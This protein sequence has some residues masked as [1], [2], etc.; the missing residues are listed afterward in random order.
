M[1]TK[2]HQMMKALGGATFAGALALAGLSGC[3]QQGMSCTTAH[4]SFA[5]K[6]TLT[7]GTGA[8]SEN[9]GGVYGVNSYNYPGSDGRPDFD[10]ASMAIEAEDIALAVEEAEGRLSADIDA[11]HTSYAKGDFGSAE[12][13][14]SDVC[15]VP[16]LTVA[17]KDIPVLPAVPD[18]PETAEDDE[19]LP[20]KPA[21]SFKYEWTNMKW[22]VSEA[23]PGTQFVADLKYTKDG[24]TADFHAIGM[25]PAVFC[26]DDEGNP[27]NAACEAEAN[28]D[29]G[30]PTGS[31][32][33]PDF[34]TEC[35]PVLLL[36]M[37]KEA[38]PIP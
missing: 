2:S 3:S 17:Q 37:L 14:G 9:P 28:P 36:C 7:S 6:L 1:S 20:E 19:S 16:T 22:R 13:N 8:C 10:K 11:A 27:D 31:G 29:E 18:D 38:P 26:G 23:V 5:V 24:C 12:P 32:I 21:E 4:G 15:S 34:Q 25:Y 33:N 35:D 30:R